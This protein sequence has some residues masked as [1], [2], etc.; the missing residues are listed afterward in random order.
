MVQLELVDWEEVFQQIRVWCTFNLIIVYLFS[1]FTFIQQN[2]LLEG[3]L[4]GLNPSPWSLGDSLLAH[5]G[6]FYIEIYLSTTQAELQNWSYI[7]M[8]TP[9]QILHLQYHP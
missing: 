6:P 3:G 1:S 2:L 9:F 5:Q 4:K 8:N 7:L